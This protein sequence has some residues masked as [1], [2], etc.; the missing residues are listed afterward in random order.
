[1]TAFALVAIAGVISLSATA[2]AQP[3]TAGIICPPGVPIDL[4]QGY[5][6]ALVVPLAIPDHSEGG[7]DDCISIPL[8]ET[9]T[10]TDL[11]VSLNITHTWVGDLV[12]SLT[13]VDTG[14]RVVLLDQPGCG[15]DNV[16]ATFTDEAAEPAEDQCN[17]APPAI[18]GFL[19]PSEAL[20]AFDG[21]LIGGTWRITVS[22]L[23]PNDTGM[24]DSWSLLPT[25]GPVSGNGDVNCSGS[26][27]SIDAALILQMDAGFTF[28][29]QCVEEGDVNGSGGMNAIDAALVL[30]Y[31][32]GI[33]PIWPLP[34]PLL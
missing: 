7:V 30:Q 17:E 11:D 26:T 31:D 18:Y 13:H 20:S 23:A 34:P 15:S 1:M 28:V 6:D 24:L 3:G 19:Q 22:D 27:D 29:L 32:A 8:A 2:S 4:G 10:I 16:R 21:E 14:T 5:R 9:Q 33:L 12:V 25:Y